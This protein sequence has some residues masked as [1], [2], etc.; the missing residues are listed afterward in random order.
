MLDLNRLKQFQAVA[1]TRSFVKAAAELDLSQPAVSRGIQALERQ[2][3]VVL[4]D[5]SRAGVHLTAVGADVLTQVNDILHNAEALERKMLEAS[6]GIGGTV[7]FGAGPF[8]GGGFIGRTLLELARQR[9]EFEIDVLTGPWS[10]MAEKLAAGVIEFYVGFVRD[11][12]SAATHD[13]R[14]IG[15][16]SYAVLARIGH[17]L[18]ER[19]S[20]EW[21]DLLRY[22]VISGRTWT[23]GFLATDMGAWL[24]GL[25]V[26]MR[27]DSPDVLVDITRN[28]DC[29]LLAPSYYLGREGLV[30]LPVGLGDS[31]DFVFRVGIFT[32]RQR[33]MSAAAERVAALLAEHAAKI[34]PAPGTLPAQDR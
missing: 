11:A 9:P 19:E 14:W 2:Y 15:R 25:S 6:E 34:T 18:A 32:L 26:S 30:P 17:P 4:L 29:L 7:T 33:T 24:H 13:V 22:P 5:R 31:G 8:A 21:D 23:D 28:S 10:E 16:M 1:R 27:V 20:V 12:P 3:S